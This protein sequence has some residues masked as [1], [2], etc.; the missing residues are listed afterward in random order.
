VLYAWSLRHRL[1]R[2]AAPA[3]TPP[4][5][6]LKTPEVHPEARLDA[7]RSNKGAALGDAAVIFPLGATLVLSPQILL[8]VELVQLALAL[9][10]LD[11]YRAGFR[12]LRVRLE[13]VPWACHLR[14]L[15]L[16]QDEPNKKLQRT[17]GALTPLSVDAN[18]G[19]QRR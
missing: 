11:D 4:Y 16:Q 17:L 15:A 13:A 19:P 1:S 10:S 2:T 12:Q 5:P 18:F 3:G 14:R 7:L 8:R 6:T 9:D